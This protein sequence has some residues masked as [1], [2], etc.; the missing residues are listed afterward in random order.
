MK[1]N[2]ARQK[3]S[4]SHKYKSR[5]LRT[6]F[7]MKIH[8]AKCIVRIGTFSKLHTAISSSCKGSGCILEPC[9]GFITN[10]IWKNVRSVEL[11]VYNIIVLL[12][13]P[14]HNTTAAIIDWQNVVIHTMRN[15]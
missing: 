1:R 10:V 12:L 13:Q 6:G 8:V 15:I 5:F 11:A 14:R 7:F 3:P 4:K 2:N 9:Y